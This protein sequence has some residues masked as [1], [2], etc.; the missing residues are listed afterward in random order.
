MKFLSGLDAAFLHLETPEMPMHVGALHLIE[1][2]PGYKG[3]FVQRLRAHVASRL[4]VAPVLSQRLLWPPLKLTNPAWVACEPDLRQQIVE[5]KLPAGS[6]LD[7]VCEKVGELHTN[8]L[9][10]DRPLWKFHVIEGLAKNE[11]GRKQVALYTQVHH[12][13]V[14]GQ[15]A[16]AL[17]R[18]L[19][20]LEPE[21]DAQR[22]SGRR[23]R[24]PSLQI[25]VSDL[26]RSALSSQAD[27]W[28]QL[29]KGLPAT[30][31]A[32]TSAA[33]QSLIGTLKRLGTGGQGSLSLAPRTRL[34]A[35]VTDRRAFAAASLPLAELKA[36]AKAH[37][38]TLNDIVL[39][40]CSTA[41]RRHFGRHGPLPRKSLVAAVPIS[42][43]AQGDTTAD[44]QASIVLIALGSE[45]A[46]PEKRLAHIKAATASMKQTVSRL[47]Q[48]LPTDFPSLGVPWMMQAVTAVYGRARLAERIPPLANVAISNVPGPAVPLYIAGA[49]MVANYPTSIVVHGVGLNITVQSY[50]ESLDFGFMACAKALPEVAELAQSLTVAFD[51][52]RLLQPEGTVSRRR[53]ATLGQALQRGARALVNMGLPLTSRVR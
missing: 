31:S 33:A 19:F 1:L 40:L 29:V 36:M 9:E 24:G 11:R 27:Q 41:L 4:A 23:R 14:D 32:V 12:A 37:Q 51:E 45:I 26:M 25:G 17:G 28:T 44:N 34:N 38:A 7:A 30:V 15:A 53:Q 8:L 43:R 18:A 50:F 21:P 10:R 16:V 49:R 35:S 20:D 52:L 46:D 3:R 47:K 42:L 22:A 6:G 2:P 13:A 48:V 39:M 5:V